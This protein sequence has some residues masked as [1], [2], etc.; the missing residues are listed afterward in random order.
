MNSAL[1]IVRQSGIDALNMR[2]LA[3]KCN[4]STQPIYLSFSGI[5]ELK[6]ELL[7][8]ISDMF[9]KR[10]EREMAAGKYPEYKATGM[11]YIFFA[12]EEKELFKFLLMR[13]RADESDWEKTSFDK[14]TTIITKNYGLYKNEAFKLHAEMWIFVHGIATMLA[15]GYLNWDDETISE[16]VTDVFAEKKKKGENK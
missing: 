13:N 8:L 5:D 3:K 2:T 4:C 11:G 6:E 15:T 12:K 9:D 10:I 14:S 1:E 16:M 7:K